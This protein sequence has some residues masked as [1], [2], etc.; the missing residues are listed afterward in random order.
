[1]QNRE[2]GGEGEKGTR[3][4]G[5]K[6]PYLLQHAKNPVDWFP[7]GEEAFSRAAREDKPV[8]LS[9]GYATCHWCHVM[10]HESFE[11]PEVAE[12]LNRDFIAIK[13]DR[14]ERPDI[15][16][17]YMQVCQ[18]LS[19]QGGWPLTIVMT[20]EKKPFFAAT[21]LPKERRFAVPGLLDLLPRIAKAWREQRGELLR[22]AESITRA[23]GTRDA[24]PAGLEPDAA[25][26]DEGYEDLLLRFDP[27]YGGFSGAPKFPTPHTLLFLLRYWKRTGKKRA[28]DMVV[29]TLDAIH[30]GG[31]HDHIGGGF[32]RYSTDAQWRVP[33]FE[34]MLYDQALLLMAY[35]E[36][37]QAT[38][39]DRY[40]ETVKSTVRYVLRDLT[41][42]EGAFYSAED[43][44]NPGGEGAFYLWTTRELEAVLGKDD[45]AI[46]G[47]VFNA[48][49]A[50]NFSSPDGTGTENILFRTLSD[51]ALT[52]VTGIPQEDLG[53][54]IASIRKQLFAAREN[55][56]HPRRDDKVLLDWNGLMIAAL[57][58]AARVFGNG[59]CRAAAERAMECI[60]VRM[61]TGDG[62]LWHRYRDGECAI[63][64]FADDYA[65]L[66]LALIELYECTFD[67]RYLAEALAVM[68]TLGD[69]F[70][71]R[72]NGG[73]FFTAD[74]AEALLVRDKVIY[75]GAVPSANSVACEVLLRLSRLTGTTE[76]EE[77]AAALARSFTGRVR[78]SPSAFCW[79][80]CAIERAVGPSQE[81]VIVGNR[82]SHAVQ[83]LLSV[84]Y[85]RYLPHCTMI[86]KPASDP[87]TVAALAAIAP[88]TRDIP[89]S[90]DG[91]AYLCS[92]KT[93][94]L[95][96]SDP[97]LLAA[98]LERN[99]KRVIKG[100]SARQCL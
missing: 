28:F 25:L 79:F 76:H 9:I 47:R 43:A 97:G 98:E 40:R 36:A 93:C 38:R 77:L 71:D 18:M 29:K 55:R 82:G 99:E 58:K 73:F 83:G 67:P 90:P 57:A 31:I 12:L 23:L 81:I 44:D 60:L 20:P 54:R 4:L 69:H 30:D 7:W 19:G 72:E 46:A 32:H 92:G 2:P 21:Y 17:T 88:Y 62:R 56:E 100:S 5:E 3:L 86:L 11:D 78:E 41:D 80:L 66:G 8:F 85:S 27:G 89:V 10:A 22:S 91:A 94:S 49:D 84:V 13:V 48:R 37:F 51:E 35:T 68:K 74:D 65:F 26:L 95:P 61:R 6:G 64:G 96:L 1:M 15:D 53:R 75:D 87:E 50:G 33:H 52:G 39:N 59:E 14:E 45:A 34:K 42:P 24:V 70:P 63:S 16:S